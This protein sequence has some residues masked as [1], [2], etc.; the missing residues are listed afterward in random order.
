MIWII[1][2]LLFKIIFQEIIYF[3]NNISYENVKI[4]DVC[5]I[6]HEINYFVIWFQ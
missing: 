4:W 1:L 3:L 6:F 2:K 5:L